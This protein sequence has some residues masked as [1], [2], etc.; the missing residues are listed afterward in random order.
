MTHG[1]VL[2]LMVRIRLVLGLGLGLFSDFSRDEMTSCQFETVSSIYIWSEIFGSPGVKPKW[3][4][5]EALTC[6]SFSL[7]TRS[8]MFTCIVKI[9]H[10]VYSI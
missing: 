6:V 8:F 7:P 9:A 2:F 10:I 4:P 1:L 3:Q 5:M